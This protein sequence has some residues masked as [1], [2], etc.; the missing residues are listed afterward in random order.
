MDLLPGDA[1]SLSTRTTNA[2]QL[3][4]VRGQLGLDRGIAARF[5]EWFSQLYF[6]ADGGRLYGSELSV[7]EASHTAFIN[8][9]H[10]ATLAL[11]LLLFIGVGAGIIA[12]LRP[13][14]WRDQ[15]SSA[16]A[17]TVLATPDFAVTTLL[18]VLLSGILGIAPTVSLVPP[19]ATAWQRPSSLIVPALALAIIGGAWLQRLV[20]AAVIEAQKLNFVRAATLR[21]LHPWPVFL[22]YT[23][24]AALAPILQAC[25]ATIPYVITGTVVVE[26]VV[27]YPGIGT[28][29]TTFVAQRETVAVASLTTIFA[30]ITVASFTFADYLGRA[31]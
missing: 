23:L 22:H 16:G 13:H 18:L 31:R 6:H 21:G 11:P 2:E 7:W 9:F 19:G 5:W 4:Q 30:A 27:G 10:L 15:V 28:M 25:A 1:A 29:L 8:T 14:S 24:P 3:A 12:G 20:R 17:Q 26:N